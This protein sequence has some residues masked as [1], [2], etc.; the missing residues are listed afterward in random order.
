LLCL[1]APIVAVVWQHFLAQTV[2]L[3]LRMEGRLALGLTVWLIYLFDRLLD[4][5]GAATLP[6]SGPH[7]FCREH[8]RAA[9]ALAAVALAADSVASFL[10]RP[11]VFWSGVAVVAG[12]AAYFES[13]PLRRVAGAWKPLMAAVLFAAGVF[14]VVWARIEAPEGSAAPLVWPA[15]AFAA[16]CLANLLLIDAWQHG[17]PAARVG[18]AA[19]ALGTTAAAWAPHPWFMAI[20]LAA[21]GLCVLA[22]GGTRWPR[23]ARRVLAD[24]VLLTPLLWILIR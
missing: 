24:L 14:L 22:F 6:D 12:V 20:A 3:P 18:W 16:L 23:E 19:A 1:D 10:L 11:A 17:R 15:A 13:F 4:V 9:I 21:W 2:G 5:R 7:W 8:Q